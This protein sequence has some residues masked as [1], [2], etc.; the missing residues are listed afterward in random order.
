MGDWSF[1]PWGTDE[2]ADWFTSYWEAGGGINFVINEIHTFS[3]EKENYESVRAACVVLECF[4]SVYAWPFTNLDEREPTLK[5][6]ITILK[7]M[8]N[9]PDETWAFLDLWSHNKAVIDNVKA[10]I[11]ALENHVNP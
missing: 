1:E 2:A 11:T 3:P 10:Q 4:G 7:N 6:A 9:P 8:L 5:K